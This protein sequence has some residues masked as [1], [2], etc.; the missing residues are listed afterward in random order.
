[1][2][3]REIDSGVVEFVGKNFD[4]IVKCD[5]RRWENTWT[6]FVTNISYMFHKE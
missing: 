3:E 4:Q 6:S 2:E 5:N 1:M